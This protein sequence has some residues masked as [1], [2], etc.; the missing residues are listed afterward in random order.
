MAITFFDLNSL[1]AMAKEIVVF[2][3]KEITSKELQSEHGSGVKRTAQD[4][5][6]ELN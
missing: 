1:V 2:K 6:L 4:T 3:D 5:G